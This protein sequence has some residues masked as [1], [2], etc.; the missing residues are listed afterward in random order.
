MLQKLM[1][2]ISPLAQSLGTRPSPS[3]AGFSGFQGSGSTLHRQT[4][5][6]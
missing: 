2:R 5:T 3:A 1:P 4:W 6:L